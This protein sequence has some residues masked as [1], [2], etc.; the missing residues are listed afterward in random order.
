MQLIKYYLIIIMDTP[1]KKEIERGNCGNFAELNN[2]INVTP[3]TS[4]TIA[5]ISH[6]MSKCR[7]ICGDIKA[8]CLNAAGLD[9][10]N[11]PSKER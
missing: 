1:T 2:K 7:S 8:E 5:D 9:K 3:M 6:V 11:M 4:F 10:E